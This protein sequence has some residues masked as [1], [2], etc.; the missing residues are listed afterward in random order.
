MW[1]WRTRNG[2]SRVKLAGFRFSQLVGE[3]IRAVLGRTARLFRPLV[4][5]DR[6][7]WVLP[8]IQQR[9]G[10]SN[11]DRRSASFGKPV[12][13]VS[14]CVDAESPGSWKYNGGIKM[15]NL[16]VKLLRRHGYEAYMV[17]YD[18]NYEPWLVEHQPH[19]SIKE[20]REKLRTVKN[21][22]CVTSWAASKAFISEC[23]KLYF[24]DMELAFTEHEHFSAVYSYLR[25]KKLRVAGCNSMICA[26]HMANWGL[27]CT[28]LADW[29]D[30]EIW[31][32]R[33]EQRK[34]YRIGYM[35]ESQHTEQ[36]IDTIR[37]IAIGAGYD[38]EFQLIRGSEQECLED[39]RSCNVFL[40]MNHG[41]DPLWGEGFGLPT[42]EAMWAGCVV[43]AYDIL[44]N[45][46]FIHDGFNGILVPRA[47][48]QLMA[49]ALLNLYQMPGEIERMRED[50][51]KMLRFCY[52]SEARWPA[53]AEFLELGEAQ[54]VL[55]HR[56]T[57]TTTTGLLLK[58]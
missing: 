47:R 11:S 23:D 51:L 22:R 54:S 39:M 12:M 10:H 26:W 7:L 31:S 8:S 32:S 13:F 37:Q 4:P 53:V 16:L 27:P 1:F 44:G 40:G 57:G 34:A 29:V 24:W 48:P 15:L 18:G 33:Q 2:L 38:F 6:S 17:T 9:I 50:T 43:I 56:Y 55:D 21:V 42:M 30:D 45:R 35:M 28:L 3:D 41:K 36:E 49:R 52:T 58:L 46:E 19:I 20:F 14:A 25:G 5:N